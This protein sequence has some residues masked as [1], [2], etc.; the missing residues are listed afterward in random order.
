MATV[1]FQNFASA[2]SR[3]SGAPASFLACIA[4]VL[5]WGAAGPLTGYS[6]V[7]LLI[8]NTL[9][10]IVT[11]LMVFLI[12]NTQN[13]EG[14]AI[15]AKLNELIRAL[16]AA[17]NKFIGIE[18]LTQKE[19]VVLEGAFDEHVEQVAEDARVEA[20]QVEQVA[21]RAEA[22]ANASSDPEPAP[23]A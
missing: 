11:L 4:L 15:Q 3:G 16:E 21:A 1:S 6:T 17:E 10:S 8:M 5:A 12:Q 14:I 22:A 2:V 18:R 23:P 19:L 7:W 20:A 13:R 9:S